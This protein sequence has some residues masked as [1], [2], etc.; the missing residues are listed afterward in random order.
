MNKYKIR[1]NIANW[2]CSVAHKIWKASGKEAKKP[3]IQCKVGR[4]HELLGKDPEATAKSMGA[5]CKWPEPHQIFI[6]IDSQEAYD[7]F[8]AR[9]YELASVTDKVLYDYAHVEEEVSRSGLPNRH[10]TISFYRYGIPVF[11]TEAE[12]ILLQA[13]FCSDA[14]REYIKTITYICEGRSGSVFFKY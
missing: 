7:E 5:K 11:I 9:F 10:I 4:V 2:L 6:D 14:I 3:I 12:R 1:K 8:I 13:F